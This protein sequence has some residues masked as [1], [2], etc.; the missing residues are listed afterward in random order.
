MGR[1][2]Q[3]LALA[4]KGFHLFPVI[5]DGKTPAIDD[6]PNKATR[7]ATQ[8]GRW[9]TGDYN[10]G[11]ATGKFG[12]DQ[13]L[14]VIDVDNKGGKNGDAELFALDM[15]GFDFPPTLEQSTPS[16]GR[17]LIYW[18]DT[19]CKQGVDVLGKGL[20]IR[21]RGGYIVGPGSELGGKPY[22]QINGHGHITK[23]PQWLVDRLGR[24]TEAPAKAQIVLPGI[25]A[26]RAEA[27][28]IEYL[29]TAP[30]SVEGEGGDTTAFMVAAKLKDLG[31]DPHQTYVL[32][33]GHWNDKCNPPWGEVELQDKV[34]HAYRYGKEPV[35]A[36]ASEAVF[37]AV[38]APEVDDDEE[39]EPHPV[40]KLNEEY[41]FIKAGAFVL[42]ETTDEH[43]RFSTIHLAVNDMHAWFANKTMVVGEKKVPLSKLWMQRASR[44]EYDAV[45]FCPEQNP[46]AR[47]YNLWRGFSV[48]PAA[49]GQHPSVQAF[50]DHAL[51]NVCKGDEKLCRWLLGYFAH[52]IQRPWEKPLVALV[53]RGGKGVGKNAL[54]ERVGDL[55]GQHFLVASDDRYLLGNFNSH[56]ESNLFFVLDEASW[57]GDKRAE[58]KLKSLITGKHHTIERKG[59][60]P[61]NVANLTRVAIIGNEDWLVPASQDER[62]FAVFNVGDGRKQDRAFFEN[63]RVGMER[64]GYAH[65]L[66][67]F[68]DFDLAGVDVNCAP[69]TTGLT[70]Q[71]MQSLPPVSEW[72]FECLYGNHLSGSS[73]DGAMPP[74]IPTNRIYEAFTSWY[75]NRGI[76]TRLPTKHAFNKLFRECSGFTE[77]VKLSSAHTGPEDTTYGYRV[78]L[79]EARARWEAFIGGPVDW[80]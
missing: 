40:D 27:R 50:L 66:K 5:Q 7:D 23:A 74:A 21:S 51:N 34:A 52:L 76:R 45:V 67:F 62:R 26:K 68:Q 60:E 30:T 31:C 37:S 25:D 13:A 53:F 75:R 4:A 3:A 64:G 79:A 16:G 39:D 2:D 70:E 69:Q 59:R 65:L 17:H 11:V 32:L 14:L 72:W 55:L 15:D 28:A 19:P 20:D 38:P 22:K 8:L 24:A 54:V 78:V 29:K 47:W 57:A 6:W 41:A 71:K 61:Y 73:F 18:T 58:G 43:G 63:M 35:G 42:Q 48:K 77:A 10:I 12:D 44:R 46:G 36:R 1:I 80:T 56:L 33:S 49:T 9:F